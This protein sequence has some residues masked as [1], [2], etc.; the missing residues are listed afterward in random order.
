[1]RLILFLLCTFLPSCFL[2]AQ[3]GWNFKSEKDY[4]KIYYRKTADLHALKLT[5]SF[6]TSQ[7]GMSQ[8][9]SEIEHYATWCYKLKE[10]HMVKAISPTEFYYYARF[11]FPWPMSDRDV[12]LHTKMEQDPTT[13][14]VIS[15]SEAVP[16]LVPPVKD[17]IRIQHANTKWTLY[18]GADGWVYTEYELYS[19]PGGTLPDWLINLTLDM[20]PRETMNNMRGFLRQPKYQNAKLA[21]IKE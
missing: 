9:L 7:S 17:V 19:D 4:V 14:V 11:N 21:F 12:V 15:T 1:M 16:D 8:L 2:H 10:A 20:G 18:P 5:T 13:N 3:N 6:K